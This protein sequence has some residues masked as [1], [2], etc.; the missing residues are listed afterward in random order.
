M[1]LGQD[2]RATARRRN[3]KLPTRFADTDA[4]AAA[5]SNSAPIAAR[6]D[7]RTA[8]AADKDSCK[9]DADVAPGETK[10]GKRVRDAGTVVTQDVKAEQYGVAQT[11]RR[12]VAAR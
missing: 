8:A 2:Q 1:S 4:A 11:K 6:S 10:R 7:T 9:V 3:I 5:A 12:R